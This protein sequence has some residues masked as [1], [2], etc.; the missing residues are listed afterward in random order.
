MI[1]TAKGKN[2]FCRLA[3]RPSEISLLDIYV[4]VE[5]PKAFSIHHY[6]V[7]KLCAV[8]CNIKAALESALDQT[9]AGMERSLSKISLADLLSNM[10]K[11]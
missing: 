7:Q 2:G 10:R 1:E 5:A 11:S 6:V 9:Q 8:S 4:A 3:R